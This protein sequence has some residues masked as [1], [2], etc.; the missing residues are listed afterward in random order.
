MLVHHQSCTLNTVCGPASDQ[1]Q[2]LEYLV[3]VGAKIHVHALHPDGSSSIRDYKAHLSHAAHHAHWL[4]RFREHVVGAGDLQL[5]VEENGQ[6]DTRPAFQ[7]ARAL[8]GV[9]VDDEDISPESEHI[10]GLL[11]LT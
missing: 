1:T 2:Y 9:A 6:R 10:G 11:Q 7:L 5:R 4:I 8:G 3:G